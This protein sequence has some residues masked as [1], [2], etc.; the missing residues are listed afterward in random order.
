MECPYQSTLT[1]NT[2]DIS[3]I[4]IK[5]H[6]RLLCYVTFGYVDRQLDGNEYLI[7]FSFFQ[8]QLT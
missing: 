5:S 1:Q 6:N 2:H 8:L 3:F 4:K 7:F